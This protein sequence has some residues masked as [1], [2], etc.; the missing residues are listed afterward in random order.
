MTNTYTASTKQNVGQVILDRQSIYYVFLI[1]YTATPELTAG[2][3]G[4]VNEIGGVAEKGCQAKVNEIDGR[5]WEKSY[6]STFVVR[7]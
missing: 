5:Y 1:F 4:F 2:S 7:V 3:K 6:A